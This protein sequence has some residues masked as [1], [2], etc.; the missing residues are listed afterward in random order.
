MAQAAARAVVAKKLRRTV[1]FA[2]APLVRKLFPY[3]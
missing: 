2:G 1:A 3:Q